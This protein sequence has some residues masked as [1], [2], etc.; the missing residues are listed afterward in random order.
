MPEI[1]SHTEFFL[2]NKY[3]KWYYNIIQNAQNRTLLEGYS[4]KHHIIPKSLGGSNDTSNLVK[5][6]ARE[7]FVCHLLLR[8]MTTGKNKSKMI[9]AIWR[10]CTGIR[11]KGMKVNNHTY[12]IIRKEFSNLDHLRPML[13]KHHTQATKDKISKAHK[14]LLCGE[15][16]HNFGKPLSVE[17]KDKI[18]KAHKGKKLSNTTKDKIS[19]ANLNKIVSIETKHKLSCAI[20]GKQ[21]ALGHHHSD[22]SKDKMSTCKKGS[23]NPNFGL[24][25]DNNPRFGQ[26][27]SNESKDKMSKSHIGTYTGTKHPSNKYIYILSNN[28]DYWNDLTKIE[29]ITVCQYF[30]EKQTDIITYKGITITRVSKQKL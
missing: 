2:D 1:L 12:E 8:K 4:E 22:E 9:Y 21:N 23:L 6:T 29:R 11:G 15:K 10:I 24:Y 13:G 5:L 30:R 17:T 7:H 19:K 26:H 27:H 18:S 16:N 3:T 20:K 14:G 25:G 28:K